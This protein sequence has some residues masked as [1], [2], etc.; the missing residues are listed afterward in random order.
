MS[1]MD[2]YFAPSKIF[3]TLREKPRWITPL[4]IIVVVIALTAGLTMTFAREAILSQQEEVLRNRGLTEEQLQQAMEF[5]SGPLAAIS[6]AVSAVIFT[7]IL[8]LIFA[9][10]VNLFIPLFGGESGFKKVFSVICHAMLVVVPAAV[11][12]VIIVALSKS[13]YVTTSLALLGPNLD[14]GS[15]AY[16]LLAGFDV[17][18]IWEMI[19]VALGISIT[20]SLVKKNAYILV[21]LVWFVSIFIGIGLGSIFGR[22]M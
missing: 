6:S 12:K 8:L 10:V 11:L 7:V 1:I 2:I 20:N 16:Q 3:S 22:G 17:F 13:P 21:F 5:T 9:L 15:F 14:K 4:I 19:L 18:T